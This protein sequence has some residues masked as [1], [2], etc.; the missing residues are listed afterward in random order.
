MPQVYDLAIYEGFRKSNPE[1]KY[2][3]VQ[4]LDYMATLRTR[5]VPIKEFDR[6]IHEGKR[7]GISQGNTG[8]LQNDALTPVVNTTGQIYVE[9]DL[10]S[11]RLTRKS[12]PLPSATVLSYWRDESGRPIRECPRSNLEILINDLQFNHNVS[13]LIGF[14]IE[15]TFLTRK[16]TLDRLNNNNN[17]N[18]NDNKPT[19]TSYEPLTHNH[20]WGTLTPEQTTTALPLLAEI[21]TSLDETG[22]S[23]LQFHS[24]SGPGQYEFILPPLPALSA[25]DTLL[26]TRQTIAQI[27]A[28][29]GL[30]AT[31]HP[32]PFPGI[33]TA[34]HA[35]ISIS[36]PDRDMQ[37]F[38]G[39]VLKHL[40]A[41]MGFAM[42]EASSYSRVVDD[43]WTG[44]RWVAWGTQNR[45]VPLRRVEDGHWELRALDG[46]ANMYFAIGAVAAAGLLGLKENEQHFEAKDVRVNPS[47]L[48]EEER[49]E[50]GVRDKLPSTVAEA[51]VA[52]DRDAVLGEMLA[53][54][55]VKDYLRMKRVELRMI[56]EMGVEGG[57]E[58]LIE[59]Y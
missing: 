58:W 38:V 47:G 37:F 2:I 18:D 40:P 51:L 21:A 25:I 10:R 24:E 9:P 1:V 41:I 35:H 29:R 23:L 28:S 15:V 17:N 27:A 34:A 11:L 3:Y 19:T 50:L 14:E 5:I 52:L 59:R 42:P 43:H 46:F 8:T 53:E 57:R 20:A 4:W 44:G 22:I 7:I 55:L 49:L 31:L 16:T 54:G 12:D 13:M 56:E 26:Q 32:Q 33:G 6:L 36:Q 45:E 48:A 30:R 39:G